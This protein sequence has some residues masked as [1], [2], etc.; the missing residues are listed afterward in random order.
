M[1]YF[2]STY[3]III[4]KSYYAAVTRRPLLPIDLIAL[5][6]RVRA[7]SVKNIIFYVELIMIILLDIIAKQTHSEHSYYLAKN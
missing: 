4:C 7:L 1:L 6:E 5:S 3:I 2:A